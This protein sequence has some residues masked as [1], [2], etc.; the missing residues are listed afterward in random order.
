MTDAAAAAGSWPAT[1]VE[2][3]LRGQARKSRP[4][5]AGDGAAA[6]NVLAGSEFAA[7][8]GFGWFDAG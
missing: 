7:S 6:E 4:Q 3:P 2:R 1:R 5:T 8:D